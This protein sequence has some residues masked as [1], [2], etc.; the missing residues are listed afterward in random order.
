MRADRLDVGCAE[1]VGTGTGIVC[2]SAACDPLDRMRP[3]PTT[4]ATP[5]AAVAAVRRRATRSPATRRR[6][7]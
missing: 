6:G 4:I 1:T 7:D 5:P 2:A 3:Q